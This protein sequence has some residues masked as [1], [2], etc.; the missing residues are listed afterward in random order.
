[1]FNVHATRRREFL[2]GQSGGKE[3]QGGAKDCL[4]AGS[5]E[6]DPRLSQDAELGGKASL[7]V[8]AASPID[9][10]LT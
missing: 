1:M 7:S 3:V 5:F 9:L 2:A 10:W 8:N 4:T 6:G